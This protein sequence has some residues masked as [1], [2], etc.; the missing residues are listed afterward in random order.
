MQLF[1]DDGSATEK[2]PIDY[3]IGHRKR[4]AEGIPV[5]MQKFEAAISGPLPAAQ[6]ARILTLAADSER[7]ETTPIE[8]FMNDFTL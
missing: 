5:L 6:V 4:R 7:L 2:R 8:V 3:P 1:F